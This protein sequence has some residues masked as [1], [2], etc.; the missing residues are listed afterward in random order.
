MKQLFYQSFT[1]QSLHSVE[2][3]RDRL[4]Q[5]V[6]PAQL[7][8]STWKFNSRNYA[9]YEGE[10]F[11]TGFKISRIIDYRNSFLPTIRGHFEPTPHGTT[12]HITLSIHPAVTAFLIAWYGIWY[13]ATIPIFLL[14]G[15]SHAQFGYS[16][17]IFLGSPIV[18]GI[19]FW[20]SFRME[21]NTDRQKLIDL[22]R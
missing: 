22:L 13:G 8:R 3:L 5:I 14:N 18:V 16:S 15:F 11:E 6:E 1:I 2:P 21:V 12:I 9:P 10:V 20:L 4:T 17:L 7:F 19:A